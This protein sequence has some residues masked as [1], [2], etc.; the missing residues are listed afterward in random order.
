MPLLR[1]IRPDGVG[2]LREIDEFRYFLAT[3]PRGERA[4]FLPF[5]AAHLQLGA[6]L[7]TLNDKVGA[8]T[9]VETEVTLWG[10]FT[11]DLVAGSLSPRSQSD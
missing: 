4:D 11:C 8:G 3:N 7:A 1:E 5:F 10:D 9:H 6:Y 2:L